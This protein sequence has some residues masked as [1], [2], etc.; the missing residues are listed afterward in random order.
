MLLIFW[1]NFRLA[2]LIELVLIKKKRVFLYHPPLWIVVTLKSDVII[3]FRTH[4]KYKLK[5]W[6]DVIKLI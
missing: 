5:Y 1:P 2:V 3:D 4:L 6:L